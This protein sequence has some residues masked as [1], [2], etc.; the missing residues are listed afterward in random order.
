VTVRMSV[1]YPATEGAAFDHDYYRDTHVP[2]A[3]SAWGLHGAEI[4]KGIDGPYVAAVHFTFD[5]LDAVQAAMGPR[6]TGD[7][8]RLDEQGNLIVLGR[9]MGMYIRGRLQRVP[10]RGRAPAGRASVGRSG[11][12][13]RSG[14]PRDRRDRVCLHGDRR[15]IRTA[16]YRRA[17]GLG[18]RRLADYKAP[19]GSSSS[20]HSR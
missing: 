15:R 14:D 3:V 6:G 17:V 18:R 11:S 7:L 2:M 13:G 19:T 12:G 1:L 10:T 9:A 8:A 4:D 5:S 20:M 16:G